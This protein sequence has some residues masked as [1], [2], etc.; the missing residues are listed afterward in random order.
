VPAPKSSPAHLDKAQ[1]CRKIA[2]AEK[3]EALAAQ[4]RHDA[5]V[6]EARFADYRSRREATENGTVKS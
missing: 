2:S 5:A 4:L 3:H 1:A 6:L